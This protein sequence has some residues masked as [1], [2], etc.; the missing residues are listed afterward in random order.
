[1]YKIVIYTKVHSNIVI[2]VFVTVSETK[3]KLLRFGAMS[4]WLIKTTIF[5]HIFGN[6]F[7]VLKAYISN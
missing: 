3:I 5:V 1:M 4:S 6:I 2:I 7:F